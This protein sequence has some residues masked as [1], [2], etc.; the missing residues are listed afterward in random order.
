MKVITNELTPKWTEE[1][2]L[3]FISGYI[4]VACDDERE[5]HRLLN[6]PGYAHRIHDDAYPA[7]HQAAR[8]V[9]IHLNLVEE[10]DV[11]SIHRWALMVPRGWDSL[12]CRD[13]GGH[14][15]HIRKACVA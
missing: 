8:D 15:R 14:G 4:V 10:W 1:G 7:L 11:A 9:G 13:C 6:N 5:L 3:D 2:F 12:D